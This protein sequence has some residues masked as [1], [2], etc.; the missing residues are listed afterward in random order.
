MIDYDSIDNWMPSLSSALEA[1]VPAALVQKLASRIK[2]ELI[3]DSAEL[4]EHHASFELV[5]TSVVGWIQSNSVRAYHGTRLDEDGLVSLQQHGLHPLLAADRKAPLIAALRHH[6]RWPE[7]SVRLEDEL[8]RH[9][10]KQK[11]GRR[12]GQVHL[13]LSRSGLQYSFNHSLRFGAEFDQRV[14]YALCV[15]TLGQH[16]LPYLVEVGL[17]GSE[18][19]SVAS[20]TDPTV[21]STPAW[22]D[23]CCVRCGARFRRHFYENHGL[24]PVEDDEN[25]NR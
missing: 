6:P 4:F 2:P 3:E 13:T 16:R 1:V 11:M 22:E 20:L 10:P 7:V 17:S 5:W 19:L 8:L 15:A 14:A 18:A 25:L 21:F 23:V 9:G 12:E 24:E